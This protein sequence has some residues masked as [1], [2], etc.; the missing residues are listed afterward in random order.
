[1]KMYSDFIDIRCPVE[2][3]LMDFVEKKKENLLFECPTCGTQVM[4]TFV[5]N[6]NDGDEI[7]IEQRP[8]SEVTHVQNIQIA[9]DGID[10]WNPSFDITPANL[11]S[12][13]ITENGVIKKNGRNEFSINEFYKK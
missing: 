11:I 3:H 8:K 12:G 2:S 7:H 5:F 6:D 1:M 4:T 9:A 13:I 10:V